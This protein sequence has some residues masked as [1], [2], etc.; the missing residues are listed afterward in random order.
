MEWASVKDE[1]K[2]TIAALEKEVKDKTSLRESKLNCD[3]NI[4][5]HK[6]QI[7]QLEATLEDNKARG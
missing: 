2:T 3:L 5:Y 6:D 1:L 4:V 7:A